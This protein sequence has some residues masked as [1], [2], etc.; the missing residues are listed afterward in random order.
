MGIQYALD[1]SAAVF[2]CHFFGQS[3]PIFVALR[4]RSYLRD[5]A[6][7]IDAH[8]ID[9]DPQAESFQHTSLQTLDET[10]LS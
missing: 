3:L 6:L 7:L 10:R 5:A 8:N 4:Q 1:R 2:H 9:I